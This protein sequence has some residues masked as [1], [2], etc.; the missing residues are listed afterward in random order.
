VGGVFEKAQ[1]ASQAGVKLFLVPYVQSVVTMYWEVIQ[2]AGP[3]Q[4]VTY[5]PVTVDL[6]EYSENAGWG[7]R[8][9]EVST[10]ENAMEPMLE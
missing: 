5:E 2:H 9:Q 8:I 1:A 6:N 3:F 7:I 4:W 10:I